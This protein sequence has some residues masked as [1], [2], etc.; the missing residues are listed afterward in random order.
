MAAYL[1][2]ILL[3]RGLRKRNVYTPE[4]GWV[5]LWIAVILASAAMGAILLFMTHDT[6]S[7]LQ[8]NVALRIKNLSLVIALG[9]LVYVFTGMVTGLRKHDFLR[10]A[11]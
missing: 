6:D 10:G 5:R 2:A 4:R 9:V 11:K 8:A 7:W 3:Y 1:N